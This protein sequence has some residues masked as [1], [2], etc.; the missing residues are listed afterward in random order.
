MLSYQWKQVSGE[1]VIGI[2][3][4]NSS[5]ASFTAPSV[6]ETTVLTFMVTVKDDKGAQSTDNV[7]VSVKNIDVPTIPTNN[8][9]NNNVVSPEQTTSSTGATQVTTDS[10]PVPLNTL[11]NTTSKALTNA[12]NAFK[13]TK[14]TANQSKIGP[15]TTPNNQLS[16]SSVFTAQG[17]GSTVAVQSNS[18]VSSRAAYD[19]IF[20]TASTGVI[21]KMEMTFPAGTNVASPILVEVS[22]LGPGSLSVSG[23][24]LTYN[25]ASPVSVPAGVYLRLE[26]WRISNPATPSSSLAVQIATKTSGGSTID[27]GTS[28]VYFVRQIGTGDIADNAI[29]SAKIQAEGVGESDIAKSA[30]TTIKI[31]PGAVGPVITQRLSASV[32]IPPSGH[33]FAEA[34]CNPDEVVSGG[35]YGTNSEKV[36]VTVSAPGEETNNDWFVDAQNTDTVQHSLQSFVMCLHLVP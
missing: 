24:T 21:G 13:N 3:N 17:I 30:I 8:L 5:K 36:I 10:S 15:T 14:T 9:A 35:G 2:Q 22:G 26:I 27:T 1:Q 33:A 31:A 18:L 28:T 12:Q 16:A 11:D 34:F 6:D 25:V 7:K 19:I 32:S 20:R 23:Q 4:A 29:T